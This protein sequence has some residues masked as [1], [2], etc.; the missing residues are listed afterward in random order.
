MTRSPSAVSFVC[1][2][3]LGSMP[4]PAAAA[5][6]APRPNVVIILTDDLGYGDLGI[7][8]SRAIATPRIDA[9]AAAGVR[10]TDFH[11]S[12]SVCTPSRA[13]LL[14]GR[15]A[16]RMGLDVPLHPDDIPWGEWL[17]VKLGYGLG[18]VGLMDLATEGGAAGLPEDEITLAEV[19]RDAGYAT[20]MV[21]KWHLGDYV[22]DPSFDPRRHGF[23]RYLGVPYS[24]DMLPFPLVRD[25]EVVEAEIADQGQLT[26]LYTEEAVRFIEEQRDEPFFLYF[27]HT[28]PHQPLFASDAFE[29][30][31]AAGLY[32]DVVAE[33]DWSVGA[34]LD[35]LDRRGVAD[36]TLVVFTSDNG[37][38][39]YGSPGGLRG[40]KGQSFEGGHR[41]PM[42]ARWPRRIPAGSV[43]DVPAINLDLFPTI[44][45]LAGA[46]PPAD[47][48]VD[49]RDMLAVLTGATTEPRDGALF[50][51]HQGTI[52]GVRRGRWKYLREM[53]HYVWPNPLNRVTGFLARQT[54]GPGPALYDLSIDPDESYNL[55]GRH[56][57]VVADL[58]R[59]LA[60][61][62]ASLEANRKG[63]R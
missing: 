26:R 34:V 30:R 41:V 45:A 33:I 18:R 51:Y 48:V 25:G 31:S 52:E 63:L 5:P 46:A 57:D 37:P 17:I 19:L 23:E 53:H 1:A 22:G 60:E 49:G 44:V 61:F 54:S 56:P 50:F 42:V 7:Y 28:F 59:T 40:R 62:E 16:K 39:F 2:L 6:A 27:A 36:D 3:V 8:G 29:G 13:G 32:G 43:S 4:A 47:R 21:G 24:N 55:A 11:A 35:A 38:W 14:T 58:A 12:D 10:L 9:L 15:Y 20:A